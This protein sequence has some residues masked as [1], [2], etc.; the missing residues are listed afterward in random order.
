MSKTVALTEKGKLLH[1]EQTEYE[2]VPQERCF[3]FKFYC[4]RI[5]DLEF[6]IFTMVPPFFLPIHCFCEWLQ[7]AHGFSVC[8]WHLHGPTKFPHLPKYHRFR[9]DMVP[10]VGWFLCLISSSFL[11]DLW[12]S[13]GFFMC[14]R[15]GS[16]QTVLPLPSLH[17]FSFSPGLG[18]LCSCPL[19]KWRSLPLDTTAQRLCTCLLCFMGAAWRYWIPSVPVSHIPEGFYCPGRA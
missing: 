2:V 9:T 12:S 4:L 1:G 3:I 10:F 13:F 6:F 17:C 14:N 8:P 7:Y 5:F 18:Y 11:F 15:S 19:V 16:P